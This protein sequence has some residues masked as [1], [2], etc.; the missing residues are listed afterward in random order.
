M[1]AQEFVRFA[2]ER[3]RGATLAMVRDVRQEDLAWRPGPEANPIGFLLFHIFRSEDRL[4]H[5]LLGGTDEV[6]DR[7][8]WDRRW[9]LPPPPPDAAELWF[10]GNSWT[11]AQV[12]A[13]KA[14]AKEEL[15]AYGE[16]AHRSGLEVLPKLDPA[17]WHVLVRPER[18]RAFYL[19][20]VMHHEAQHQGQIDYVAG[21]LRTRGGTR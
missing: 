10:T 21:I 16:Q 13:W 8:G 18:T 4:L 7:E 6:W 17:Q 19:H 1:D 12:A 14:P 5:R 2:I 9:R 20:L 11:P 15:L 3:T